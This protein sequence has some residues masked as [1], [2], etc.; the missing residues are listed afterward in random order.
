VNPYLNP[1]DTD[2]LLGLVK[3]VRP[4]VMIEFGC[5][6]GRTA[7]VLLKQV[8][9]LET[10]IGIDVPFAH[11]PALGC[12]QSE[13][14]LYPGEHAANDPRFSVLLRD[15]RTLTKAD[16]EPCDAVFIDGDHSE[17]AVLHDSR[18]ARELVR[19]GGIIV[20]HDVG[21]RAVEVDRALDQLAWPITPVANTWIAFW[22]AD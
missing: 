6:Y 2:A 8:P 1:A 21:N 16:L 9:T 22:R 20:W 12:Q 18:L 13:V 10:Y 3:S 14:P 19:P 7:A 5:N 11:R 15:S 17:A 4:R